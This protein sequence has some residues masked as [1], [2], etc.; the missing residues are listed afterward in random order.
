MSHAQTEA[1]LDELLGTH[2]LD[3]EL[4]QYIT[5]AELRYFAR[6][7][8]KFNL[9]EEEKNLILRRLYHFKK[10]IAH[11][12]LRWKEGQE[13][14]TPTQ[15]EEWSDIFREMGYHV[16]HSA[17][18][19]FSGNTFFKALRLLLHSC[20]RLGTPVGERT[21]YIE[22]VLRFPITPVVS[23]DKLFSHELFPSNLVYPW[24]YMAAGK[25]VKELVVW[26]YSHKQITGGFN[27]FQWERNTTLAHTVWFGRRYAGS[28]GSRS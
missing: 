9:T 2:V 22:F 21:A 1:V 4:M 6:L 5:K 18:N 12:A 15:K 16:D 28:A 11:F 24:M 26:R 19:C 10:I 8:D 20:K 27:T 3:S 25:I 17:R 23:I 7:D 13:F 14:L